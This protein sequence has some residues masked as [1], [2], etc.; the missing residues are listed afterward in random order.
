MV[1]ATVL[2]DLAKFM[3]PL[4]CFVSLLDSTGWGR[5]GLQPFGIEPECPD[6][7]GP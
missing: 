3:T 6:V 5:D 4:N 2:R 1:T 7:P